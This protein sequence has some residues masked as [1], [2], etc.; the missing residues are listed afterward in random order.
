MDKSKDRSPLKR[1]MWIV[2]AYLIAGVIWITFSDAMV[3]AWFTDPDLLTRV[4]TYKGLAF[5]VATAVV[6]LFVLLPQFRQEQKRSLNHQ[7]QREE[8]RLLSQFQQNVIDNASV[9]INVLDPQ[10]HVLLWNKAA[11]KIS[12]Y[13]SHEVIGG[14]DI[15]AWL[16]PDESYRAEITALAGAIL[17]D[18]QEVEDYETR[19]V[20]REGLTRIISWNSRCIF[21]A[22]GVLVGSIAIGMDVTDKH[23]AQSGLKA[24]ER[25]LTTLMDNLPGMA[26]RCL[27]DEF[28][29]M[30]F[31]SS[32]CLELTG[33][34]PKELLDN[35]DKAFVDLIFSEDNAE[36]IRAVEEAIAG[37]E[38]FSL[39]Y[40]LIRK[41]GRLVWVWERGRAVEDNGELVLEGIIL[42]MSER[43]ALEQELSRLATH[44][45]LTGL[46]NRREMTRLLQEEV[47]RS[48][49]YHR[50]LALLWIDIDHF[51][52]VNDDYGHAVGDQVLTDICKRLASSIRSVDAIGRY[53]GEEF[54]VLL[55]EMELPEALETAERLRALVAQQTIVLGGDTTLSLTISVGVAVFPDHGD[56]AD[57]LCHAADQA[58]YDAKKA[59]RNQ[60]RGAQ[61]AGVRQ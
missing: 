58:M 12:G 19:I 26:Y 40:R 31:I 49:R 41:D 7:H 5:V 60:V 47:S 36:V 42:D 59:G 32:G 55:P 20:T 35:R 3:K 48:A 17:T 4:Q 53:G 2:L 29:T 25:Q 18:N 21:D 6:L 57:A 10:A 54:V 11:E 1:S 61:S 39:E 46:Y 16:Y 43:K 44:D 30:K 52:A 50:H 23:E 9:W 28:W 27:Y 22:E 33:Y 37:A 56:N 51:K 15:W 8:I 14:D 24:R 13:P 45:T 38:S 34:E